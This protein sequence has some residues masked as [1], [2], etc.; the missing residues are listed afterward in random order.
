[1]RMGIFPPFLLLGVRVEFCDL[2]S[3]EWGPVEDMVIY[4]HRALLRSRTGV[5]HTVTWNGM[6]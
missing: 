1:M 6:G 4:N 2:G 5:L 3:G